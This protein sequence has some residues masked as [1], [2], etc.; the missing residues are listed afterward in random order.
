MYNLTYDKD[1]GYE[2]V[3]W[4]G[5]VSDVIYRRIGVGAGLY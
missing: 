2:E 4:F 1:I 3:D 5:S